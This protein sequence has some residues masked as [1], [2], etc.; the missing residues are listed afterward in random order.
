[1]SGKKYSSRVRV[2][3]GHPVPLLH[4]APVW[5][6][7][8]VAGAIEKVGIIARAFCARLHSGLDPERGLHD[9]RQP[10]AGASFLIV[11]APESWCPVPLEESS[12]VPIVRD[13]IGLIPA[14]STNVLGKK[15]SRKPL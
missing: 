7:Y 1:M 15:V 8:G 11:D 9:S 10:P 14:C 2:P 13:R 3:A 12:R 4:I 6:T 5:I